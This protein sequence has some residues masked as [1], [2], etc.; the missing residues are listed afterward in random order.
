MLWTTVKRE[1][2]ERKSLLLWTAVE[3]LLSHQAA[4]RARMERR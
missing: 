1:E 3:A 4:G 2:A